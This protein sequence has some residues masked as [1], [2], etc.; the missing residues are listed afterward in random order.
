MHGWGGKPDLVLKFFHKIN[1]LYIPPHCQTICSLSPDYF[2]KTQ[3]KKEND[4]LIYFILYTNI[5]KR[6]SLKFF[7]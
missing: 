3:Y 5:N 4:I 6:S 2:R 1:T 7:F